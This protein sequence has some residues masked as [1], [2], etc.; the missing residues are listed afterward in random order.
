M[1]VA[2]GMFV[3]GE[4]NAINSQIN[5]YLM[6]RVL[7][8]S[9]RTAIKHGY[10]AENPYGMCIVLEAKVGATT[11]YTSLYLAPYDG[12][13][14]ADCRSCAMK[15]PLCTCMHTAFQIYAGVCWAM[16][17]YLFHFQK[18]TLQPSMISSLTYLYLDS[19]TWPDPKEHGV[20]E[21]F[22]K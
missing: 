11:T 21:W 17:I 6:S 22:V 9:V 20:V 13:I 14:S 2:G 15:P 16:A 8:G 12:V 19:N 5:M 1:F 10:I 3:F 4:N 18:G 7:M